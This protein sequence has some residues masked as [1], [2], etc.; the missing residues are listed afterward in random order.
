MPTIREARTYRFEVSVPG[1]IVQLEP[2]ELFDPDD[3]LQQSGR[4]T[5]RE[6]VGVVDTEV[7]TSDGVTWRG[8][9]D[10]R[11][12]KF[13]DESAFGQ[14]LA[15]LAQLA[16]ESLHQGFA[17]SAGQ[18]GAASGPAP[19]LMYQQF[20]VLRALLVGSDLN[21]AIGQVLGSPNR[22][23]VTA[24][25]PRAPGRPL[26]GS[27]RL[28]TQLSRPGRR[29]VT[30]NGPLRSLP[31]EL[32]VQHTTETL[33][34]VPNRFVLFVLE[35]WRAL[36]ESVL[37]NVSELP[38][39]AM[40]RGVHEARRVR[41]QLDEALGNPLFNEVSRLSLVPGDNQVLRRREGYRQIAAASALIDGSLGLEVNLDDP[42]LV[43]RRSIATLYEYW[44]FTRLARSVAAVCGATGWQGQLFQPSRNGMS[45]VLNTRAT[46]RLKFRGHV[47][48]QVIHA[49][50]LFNNE[51]SGARSWTRPM[52]PDASLAIRTPGQEEVWLHFDAKYKVEWQVP[53]D[54]GSATDEEDAERLGS[55]KRTDLLKMHAYRDAIRDSAG[56]YVLFPGSQPIHFGFDD[57]TSNSEALPGLGAFPL[58]PDAIEDDCARL[59]QFLSRAM[60]HLTGAG[61][62]HR[63]ATFWSRTAY[64]GEGTAS[65]QALPPLGTLP[66]ADTP[67]LLGYVR[68]PEQWQ[69]ILR[70]HLY[71]IRTGS[72]PGAVSEG[73]PALDA[74]LLIA[75]GPGSQGFVRLFRRHGGWRAASRPQMIE[76]GYP[77]PRG[78]AYLLA[79]I[80]EMLAPDW[81][82]ILEIES[83]RP[84]SIPHGAPST[85][86][87]LD[88]VLSAQSMHT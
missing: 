42:L 87:W 45:L 44:T 24:Y 6:S 53:F 29:V 62:K 28:S 14:M 9:F 36:S 30:P 18:F 72:R 48:G 68:S 76:L 70:N 16:V 10:V 85:T 11:S 64:E 63:R 61:T 17:P 41:D 26:Q 57:S 67:V 59:E 65:P 3:Q 22:E 69:W 5:P 15:D 80:E 51:F 20:A 12:A 34:T 2:A 40:R 7:T 66:P 23:W 52:R 13:A 27:S 33:D 37:A 32:L 77:H 71:N 56:S 81:L 74:Q 58:R 86:T 47:D 55:S 8:R 38:G 49:D 78:D 21:W 54:T 82:A 4:L 50:L 31:A 46:S 35:R 60:R 19:Q 88:L 84:P 25:E 79:N 43:S 1:S 39:A 75:Y 83:L 73:E